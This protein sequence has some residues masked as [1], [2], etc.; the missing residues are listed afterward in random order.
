MK[1]KLTMAVK[2]WSLEQREEMMRASRGGERAQPKTPLPKTLCEEPIET[3]TKTSRINI[4][5]L[6]V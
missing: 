1:L 4:W 2:K 5:S 6:K 3:L